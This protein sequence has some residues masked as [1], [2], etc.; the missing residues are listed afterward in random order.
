MDCSRRSSGSRGVGHQSLS[1]PSVPPTGG[2]AATGGSGYV[3]PA[4]RRRA[5]DGS[6]PAYPRRLDPYAPLW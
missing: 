1:G 3:V 6:W 2:V 4:R 5:G